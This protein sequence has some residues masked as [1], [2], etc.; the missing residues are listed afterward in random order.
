MSVTPKHLHPA[1]CYICGQVSHKPT[2]THDFISNFDMEREM[3]AETDERR[4]TY[5][6]EAAYVSQHRPY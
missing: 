6:T 4:S 3:Q 2:E 1:S 5:S